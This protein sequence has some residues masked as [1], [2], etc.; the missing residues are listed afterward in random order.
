MTTGTAPNRTECETAAGDDL[1]RRAES[2]ESPDGGAA[3]LDARIAAMIPAELLQPSEIIILLIKP[4]PW[5]I[6]LS[7]LGVLALIA[8]ACTI[9][10]LLHGRGHLGF[11]SRN[12]FILAA[13]GV[14][15]TKLFWQFLDWLS[16]LYVL[17]D[18][19]IIR[20]K[21]VVRVQVFETQLKNVQ[22]TDTIFTFRERLFGLGTIAFAT[23]GTATTE[24]AWLMVAQPL[25][26]HRIVVQAIGRYGR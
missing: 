19:R 11:A 6:L 5:Y 22:H 2:A 16:R 13:V 26:V 24:A 21:G 12:D 20:V 1:S 7:S 25:E 9:L 17:T 14:A 8:I 23:S 10:V 18:Q 15:L 3:E 4:S